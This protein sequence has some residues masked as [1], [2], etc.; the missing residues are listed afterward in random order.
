[1]AGNPQGTADHRHLVFRRRGAHATANG[2]RSFAFFRFL[3]G[4]GEAANW[5]GATKTVS[6]WFPKSERGWAVA[7]FD[8]GSSVGGAI[9]PALVV[10]LYHSF[11]SWRPAFVIT[12][13]LGCSVA[14]R[15]ESSLSS[16]GNASAAGGNGTADAAPDPSAT[17]NEPKTAPSPKEKVGNS[18]DWSKLLSLPQT[19]GII[20]GR[21]LTDP[22][23]FF[24]TDWF[25]IFLVAKGFRLENTLIGFWIPFLAADLGNF[26]GGGFSSY[27]IETRLARA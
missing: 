7:L 21:S 20:L 5:P 11:G 27:L 17:K 19:W 15:L 25:A 16:A 3:L 26:F 10:W 2:L 13:L 23:W 6:E 22:V 12:G 4:C 14:D 1:M 24:I 8:S 18:S 9:A